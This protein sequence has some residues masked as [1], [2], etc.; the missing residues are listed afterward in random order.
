MKS[1]K[2]HIVDVVQREVF[3]GVHNSPYCNLY[4]KIWEGQR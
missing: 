2:G 1:Y 3:D 4:R